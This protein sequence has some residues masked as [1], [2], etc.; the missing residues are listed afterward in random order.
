[1]NMKQLL[2]V[3]I[4]MK[5]SL[6]AFSTVT[7]QSTENKKC[8]SSGCHE[9]IVN[10]TFIHSPIEDDCLTCH[11]FNNKKHPEN[12]G[13]EFTLIY[14]SPDLCYTCHDAKNEMKYVHSPVD[15]GE[16]LD[17]HSPH[18]SSQEFLL[19]SNDDG[20]ICFECHDL[21]V[22][23]NHIQHGPVISNQCN[24]CHDAHQ[25]DNSALLKKAPPELCFYCHD[26]KKQQLSFPYVHAA[27][28]DDCITCHL[29]HNAPVTYL[30]T[31]EV[32]E[33]CFSCHEEVKGELGKS[34]N[35]HGPFKKEGKCYKCHN[36][37]ASKYERLLKKEENQ[38]CFSCHGKEF[39]INERKIKN[40]KEKVSGSKFVHGPIHDDGC[41][42]CH[43]AHT[44]DNFFLLS[45]YFPKF[46]YAE[47]TPE[48]FALCFSCHDKDILEL[49]TTTTITN[50]RHGSQNL[51]FL[52]VSRKKGRSCITCHDSHGSNN[53]HLIADKVKFGNWAMPINFNITPDG[54]SCLP[55]CHKK[56]QYQRE[57]K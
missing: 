54:G 31:A 10:Q 8:G 56:V 16:C 2:V 27:F 33:L 22:E 38:L 40:I 14:R 25:S 11:E 30:L 36:P 24:T 35:L 28:E 43:Q 48:K 12:R 46:A 15:E 32:P 57:F 5:L 44:P 47:G 17:C 21:D 19:K 52:H 50:F 45:D 3:F 26:H 39:T 34:T 29:P 7:G 20:S 51:H 37:H 13:K 55:G 18:G 1:M 49:S 53:E 42:A 23:N 4:F 41:G 9:D 6:F